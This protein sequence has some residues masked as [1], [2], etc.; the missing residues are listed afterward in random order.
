MIHDFDHYH[1]IYWVGPL[2]GALLAATF[3]KFIKL[4]EYE[5]ANPGQDANEDS[6]PTVVSSTGAAALDDKGTGKV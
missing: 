2:L 5:T 3:Y 1:W 6:D 4:L